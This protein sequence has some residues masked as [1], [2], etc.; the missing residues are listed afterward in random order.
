[1]K[2]AE[3]LVERAAAQT[4]LSDLARRMQTSARYQEG[5]E[6][7][8]NSRELL[9]EYDRVALELEQLIAR[10]NAANIITEVEPGLSMTAAIA[11][12][13]RLQRTLR[14][15]QELADAG[16]GSGIDR[17]MRSELRSFAAVDVVALRKEADDLARELRTLDVAIQ[18]VNWTTE[19]V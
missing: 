1:M 14:M 8:E 19:I 6:P 12:R 10:I 2:L 4:R 18:S 16:T 9:A 13:E 5:Q 17:Q 7:L 15:R 3:A 11:R